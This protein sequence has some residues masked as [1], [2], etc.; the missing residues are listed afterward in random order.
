MNHNDSKYAFNKK[1]T[2]YLS[3]CKECIWVIII[4]LLIHIG[5]RFNWLKYYV[6]LV[7]II[8]TILLS[9]VESK[10]TT[11]FHDEKQNYSNYSISNYYEISHV[12][13]TKFLIKHIK[14]FII[15][16]AP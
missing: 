3:I 14:S 9:N 11:H 13:S 15:A 10:D 16:L 1:Y 2:T 8:Q 4:I 5:N 6:S 7:Y 12:M